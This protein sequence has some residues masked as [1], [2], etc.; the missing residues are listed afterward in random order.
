MKTSDRI[1]LVGS[2]QFALS[3][4]L[5][6]NCHLVRWGQRFRAHWYR[7]WIRGGWH[8]E[9][10][11]GRWFRSRKDPACDHDTGSRRTVGR[12]FVRALM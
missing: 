5:G 1:C 3:H 8:S 6:C 11:R 4:P 9:E 10:R 2:E 7:P 12:R